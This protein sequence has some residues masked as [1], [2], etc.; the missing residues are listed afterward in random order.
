MPTFTNT[1]NSVFLDHLYLSL[2]CHHPL[3]AL[4]VDI[5]LT[6]SLAPETFNDRTAYDAMRQLRKFKPGS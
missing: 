2:P 6:S 1:H 5:G 4:V 3:Q